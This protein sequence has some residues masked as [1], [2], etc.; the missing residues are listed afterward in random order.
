MK[1]FDIFLVAA[2]KDQTKLPFVLEGIRKHI[3]GFSSIY[4]STP[5]RL[6][7]AQVRELG[8]HNVLDRQTVRCR[9]LRWQHRPAWIF[10]QMLKL[11]QNVTEKDWW[12]VVDCDTVILRDLPLW[13]GERPIWYTSH[14]QNNPAY[15]RFQEAMWGFG[16]TYPHSFIADMG[17]YNRDMVR[18][19]LSVGGY[20]QESF[21]EKSYS[22]IK[23]DCYPCEQDC[24]MSFMEKY[25]TGT[26]AIKGLRN[27]MLAREHR[28]PHTTEWK[29]PQIEQAIR[30]HRDKGFDTVAIHD[31]VDKTHNSWS[32][33]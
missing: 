16:R 13:D 9:P 1:P 22:T 23:S 7:P 19:L 3:H 17:F 5:R 33:S 14:D 12:Y 30:E 27:R 28:N 26:Y 10:Q 4:L 6:Q 29:P 32:A 31:W 8:V 24:Y 21:F 18:E 15:Y 2:P 25:H 20:T 11:F